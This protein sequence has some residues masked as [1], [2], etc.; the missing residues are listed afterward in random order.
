MIVVIIGLPM[1]MTW[2]IYE[3]SSNELPKLGSVWKSTPNPNAKGTSFVEGWVY[4]NRMLGKA[5]P[6]DIVRAK[7]LG[8][9]HA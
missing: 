9:Y 6:E 8:E 7:L 2:Q 1:G 3:E 4:R 5:K